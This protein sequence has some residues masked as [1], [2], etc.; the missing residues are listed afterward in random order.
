MGTRESQH[1]FEG[2]VVLITGATSGIGKATAL[3]FAEAGAK[4]VISGRREAKGQAVVDEAEDSGGE[5]TFF[6]VDVTEEAAIEGLVDDTLETY[7]RLD[8]AFN[9]A[10]TEHR[11]PVAEAKEADYRKVFDTNVWGVLAAMKYETRAL[12]ESGGGV[13]INTS[14]VGGHVGTPGSSIYVGSKH[15]VEGLT[16]SAAQELAG[17]GIR[18]NAVSPGAIETD[19][20]NRFVGD[21][22]S[23]AAEQLAD[24]IPLQHIGQPTDIAQ[25]VLWLASDAAS[26]VTGQ[27]VIVDG[28]LTGR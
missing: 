27:S 7:G 16:K 24:Q 21:A 3:A 4:V 18:V 10:G 12:L 13:I 9:N 2:K 6:E 17:Q 28:G 26:Y 1:N 5:A 14:S 8:I 23:E 15:A 25:S 11:A 19:M 22:E 20:L